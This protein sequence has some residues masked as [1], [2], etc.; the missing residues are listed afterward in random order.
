MW[1]TLLL[2]VSVIYF[3]LLLCVCAWHM[4]TAVCRCVC[5]NRGQG[6]ML[7]ILPYHSLSKVSPWSWDWCFSARQPPNSSDPPASTST[8]LEYMGD[9]SWLAIRILGSTL[10]PSQMNSQFSQALGHFSSLTMAFSLSLND[11]IQVYLLLLNIWLDLCVELSIFLDLFGVIIF[12]LSI[13]LCFIIRIVSLYGL[14][15]VKLS[16]YCM[17]KPFINWFYTIFHSVWTLQRPYIFINTYY[18]HSPSFYIF[19]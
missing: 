15:N 18:H 9:H 2:G 19:W 13:P 3:L 7:S 11:H 16:T 4:R 10:R 5:A 14:C 8:V 17:A 1:G 12:C 6:R